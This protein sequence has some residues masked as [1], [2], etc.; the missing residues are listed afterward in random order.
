MPAPSS[1][2]DAPVIAEHE[3]VVVGAGPAGIGAGCAA[4]RLG[5]D[6][7]VV[8]RQGFPGGVATTCCC[9][10]LM[11]FATAGRQV[12]GGLADDLVRE[13]DRMG[14]ARLRI[15]PQAVP[16]P[17]PIG[18]RAI[19]ANVITS[20]EGVRLAA[21]RLLE[22]SGAGMLFYAPV[23][24]AISDGDRVTAV[25]V[26]RAEG[27]GLIRARCFVDA[28][29]DAVVVHRAGG[30]T[31]EAPAGEAATKTILIRVGGVVD[32]DRQEVER[33]FNARV[34]AGAVPL[35]EQDRFMG[36]ALLNP[37][38]VLLN[39]TLT[40][41]DGLRSAELSRMD[42]DLREQIPVAV[43]W[44]REHIPGFEECF[45]VDSAV[46]VGVR[47]GRSIVGHETIT[48]GDI[49]SDAPVPEP[50]ALGSRSYGGHG[51][52]AF[53]SPW[54]KSHPGTRGIPWRSLLPVS[55]GNVTAGG[56]AISCDHRVIDTIR[57]MARCM[58]T[59][60]GAGVTAALAAE[61]G[62]DALAV[63]Y[64]DVREALLEEG[65]ILQ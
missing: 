11:G 16:D 41:G 15:A 44:F 30:E 64:A 10:F 51:L 6:T 37:G 31:R 1:P 56:R 59:G 19:T 18:E 4:A 60:Q 50:V 62:C 7:L 5:L 40:A 24:D 45:H 65:A 20:V 29:G 36:V 58:A 47:V 46:R 33:A 35:P 52:G 61:R 13:L 34:D 38:E 21:A 54:A 27:P 53:S 23:I 43:G 32:F 9:P 25:C 48:R 2:A 42:R 57:L 17:E 3:V 22:R 8:E 14:Q 26:D 12:I 39:F 28:T 49:D 55:F 63:G